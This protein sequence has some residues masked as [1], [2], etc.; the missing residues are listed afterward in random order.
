MGERNR[1]KL[2]WAN[3]MAAR[4]ALLQD[5]KP[6][7]IVVVDDGSTRGVSAE[8]AEFR[9]LPRFSMEMLQQ[10]NS[11]EPRARLGHVRNSDARHDFE[12]SEK[13]AS[14]KNGMKVPHASPIIGWGGAR[15][16]VIAEVRNAFIAF[17]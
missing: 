12:G 15:K 1:L 2:C 3:E 9:L 11:R 17:L 6:T 14:S 10:R 8:H 13:R 16:T 7:E 4:W 5:R